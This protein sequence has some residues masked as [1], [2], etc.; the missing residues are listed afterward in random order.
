[1][2]RHR[3]TSVGA[4]KSAPL[5]NRS[6]ARP[7]VSASS[8]ITK[9]RLGSQL[10]GVV[11]ASIA[12][13]FAYNAAS[14]LGV[15]FGQPNQESLYVPPLA[16]QTPAPHFAKAPDVSAAPLPAMVLPSAPATPPP[17]LPNPAPIHWTQ[18]K[19]LVAAGQA[20]LVDVR[21]K[22]VFDAGHIPG[23][24]SLPETS[25]PEEFN[26]FL[27]QH[28]TNTVL[29]VYCS[30]A[31]CSQSARVAA[32]LVTQFQRRDV[33]FMAGGYQEYQQAEAA[34]NAASTQR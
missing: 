22:A 28:A 16:E 10:A 21:A 19:S 8:R 1:M 24:C 23:A 17:I 26:T 31:S 3:K 12:L 4:P 33:K 32:R 14:P 5:A 11:G 27:Q 30:S 34:R 7:P 20:V 18:A 2:S 13:G 9:R 15:R 25:S 6:Q 29:I